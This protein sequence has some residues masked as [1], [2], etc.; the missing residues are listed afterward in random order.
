MSTERVL[1]ACMLGLVLLD[2][3]FVQMTGAAGR[4]WLGAL[5]LLTLASPFL[6]RFRDRRVYRLAWNLGLIAIFGL[7]VRHSVRAD[8][9][10]V[11]E[12]G[13]LLA[14]FCQVHLLNNLRSSQ[15]VELLFVN[16]FLIA[17]IAAFM[18]SGAAFPIAFLAFAG[19]FVV[20]L[21]LLAASRSGAVEHPEA[22]RHLV[23]DGLRRAG[24]TLALS[25]A[26]FLFWPRDF[27][28][29][30]FF[31]GRIDFTPPSASDEYEVGFSEVLELDR[32]GQVSS[33]DQIVLRA[34]LL[35]GQTS[36]VTP[37]WRG[38]TLGTTDG[39][40]W[41][42]LG[43][44]E[45]R[46]AGPADLAWSRE[47]DRWRRAERPEQEDPR[48]HAEAGPDTE[49]SHRAV[50]TV[51]VD[52]ERLDMRTERLFLPLGARELE[53]ADT[54]R[55]HHDGTLEVLS[56]GTTRYRATL[57]ASSEAEPLGGVRRAELP[58]ELAPYVSLP[59]KSRLQFISE[60][61]T[62]L[63]AELPEDTEQHVLAQALA[64]HLEETY[65]YA[66]PGTE[67]AARSLAEFLRGEAPGHCEFFASALATMLRSL[68]I[69]C[70]VVTGLRS[71]RWSER[72]LLFA[73]S[74]AHA[75][76]EVHDPQAGWYAVDP[77][78]LV[79]V[80]L[81]G[82]GL[83]A[84]LRS[85][86]RGFWG[87]VSGFDEEGR[88]TF[89]AFVRGLPA[90]TA[91]AVRDQPLTFVGV[92]ALV[93]LFLLYRFYLRRSGV[94]IALRRYRQAVR[95]AGLAL[96]SGETPRELLARARRVDPPVR[97]LAALEAATHAHEAERY[98]ART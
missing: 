84:R 69:P 16:A 53:L 76:V 94:P 83:W 82:R 38:A 89:F 75:W 32:S 88:A 72:T 6:T 95:A 85:G 41:Q 26:V 97:A 55:P 9:A 25:L 40:A 64:E 96:A 24:V 63:T 23:V 92:P 79:V 37:L 35:D 78:P 67:G 58:A 48:A 21:Q 71:T 68:D 4:Q 15:P 52:V 98:R 62:N 51:E 29:R 54:P 57:Q 61:A 70:R 74:D 45:R 44:L 8:M 73:M 22:A 50:D 17:I 42:G 39:G 13:L 7:L 59:K 91:R 14:A 1:R 81:Q 80:G 90:R 10:N 30:A 65:E 49:P 36:A 20:G 47:G 46:I 87:A 93:A 12:L 77:S 2:M 43:P 11:L 56:R 27:E 19:L 34:T 28:R 86:A 3:A 31:H 33:S 18:N 60:L 5:Y 66:P